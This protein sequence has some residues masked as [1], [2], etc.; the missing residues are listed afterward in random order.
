MDT[1][2]TMFVITICIIIGV[3]IV[4]YIQS[5]YESHGG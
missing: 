4:K 5:I 2:Q 3:F 1:N